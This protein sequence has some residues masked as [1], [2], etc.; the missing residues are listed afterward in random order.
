MFLMTRRVVETSTCKGCTK[1]VCLKRDKVSY[2]KHSPNIHKQR[3]CLAK[4]NP[5]PNPWK[6]KGKEK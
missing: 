4:K 3:Q 2:C 6:E 1:I 5:Y